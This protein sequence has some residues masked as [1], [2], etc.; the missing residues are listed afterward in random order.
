[1]LTPTLRSVPP[2]AVTVI[3]F[4]GSAAF[5]P[6]PG[7]IRTTGPAGDGLADAAAWVAA[8]FPAA[9]DPLAPACPM[10]VVVLPVQAATAAT[11]APA[12]TAETT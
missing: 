7:V 12:A 3:P 2:A 5:A 6:F 10:M 9:A 8:A 11:S 4:D 1:M